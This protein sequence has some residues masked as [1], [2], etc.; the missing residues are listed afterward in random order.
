M[1]PLYLCFP[2]PLFPSSTSPTILLLSLHPHGWK[3]GREER[4]I[5]IRGRAKARM[6]K[7]EGEARGKGT[8]KRGQGNERRIKREQRKGAERWVEGESEKGHWERKPV[9]V[10]GRRKEGEG[11][12]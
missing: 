1:L 6:S 2:F 12:G 9:K 11:R 3:E 4:G 7:G 10:R 5:D 8:R